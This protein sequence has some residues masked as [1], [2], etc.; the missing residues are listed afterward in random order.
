MFAE[1]RETYGEQ[2][3]SDN[4]LRYLLIKRKFNPRTAGEV[5]QIYK[6]TVEAA[7]GG[8]ENAGVENQQVPS[9]QPEVSQKQAPAL[10]AP[11]PA[12]QIP[13][14]VPQAPLGISAINDGAFVET[15]LCRT[16]VSSRARVLFEGVVTKES[17]EKL[18]GYLE[19]SKDDHPSQNSLRHQ[20]VHTSLGMTHPPKEDRVSEL[21]SSEVSQ[22]SKSKSAEFGQTGP[23]LW[24]AA[25][26][27]YEV[28]IAGYAGERDGVHYFFTV[29]GTGLPAQE[30]EFFDDDD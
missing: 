7:M 11:A 29:T 19:L 10:I 16:S 14:Q 8:A 17:I 30:V 1:F 21:S 28:E 18:I 25:D 5:I 22:L 24:R 15:L 4:S 23:A 27:D 26:A 20:S 3:P 6:D 13:Q 2:L 9:L 12:T